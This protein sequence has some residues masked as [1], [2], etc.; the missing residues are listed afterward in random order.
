MSKAK[1]K[2]YPKQTLELCLLLYG[3]VVE[4]ERNKLI[5]L[6]W[7]S[8]ISMLVGNSLCFYSL[9]LFIDF[10]HILLNLTLINRSL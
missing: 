5:L 10:D 8:Q 1:T 2:C 6:T 9:Y 4:V 7:S 3:I